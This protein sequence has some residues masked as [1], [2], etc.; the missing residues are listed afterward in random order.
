MTKRKR[1]RESGA[2]PEGSARQALQDSVATSHAVVLLASPGGSWDGWP[3]R[4][5][6][7][8]DS[9]SQRPDV[10]VPLP[11]PRSAK[12]RVGNSWAWGAALLPV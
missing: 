5:A 2:A 9:L 7:L 11:P 12:P 10:V 1:R 4:D 8:T 3:F 6:G